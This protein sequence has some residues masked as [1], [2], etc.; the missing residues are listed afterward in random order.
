[1]RVGVDFDT[2]NYI[3]DEEDGVYYDVACFHGEWFMAAVVDCNTAS[4]TDTLVEDDG[5]Y[6]TKELALEGGR[7]AAIEWCITNN[8][9]WKD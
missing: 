3:G 6:A 9:S 8:V 4:F 5:P 2:A 7:N 1:M